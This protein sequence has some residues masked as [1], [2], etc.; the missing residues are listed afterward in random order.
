[1]DVKLEKIKIVKINYQLVFNQ[2][3]TPKIYVDNAFSDSV[4][5]SSLLRL[6]RNEVLDL[7]NQDSIFLISSLISPKTLVEKPTKAYID[8]LHEENERSRRNLGVDF[9][10]ET[11]VLERNNQDKDYNDNKKTNIGSIKVNRNPNS[12]NELA[13]KKY[14]ADELDK[15]TFLGFNLTLQNYLK[16][17]VGD[18]TYTT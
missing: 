3:L 12:D 6:D 11:S 9:Y 10:D 16:V 8:S 7:D 18:D 15:N 1:M 5:E 13:Y 2:H 17:S 4:D 14:V